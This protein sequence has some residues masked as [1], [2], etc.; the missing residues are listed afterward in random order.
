[1]TLNCSS[2]I[3]RERS[4][5]C[6]G[7]DLERDWIICMECISPVAPFESLDLCNSKVCLTSSCSRDY[8]K[9]MHLP[10]RCTLK[11]RK[12]YDR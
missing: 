7:R 6:C 5:G 1:M 9:E 11:F 3:R 8:L 2:E 12:C 10:Q 4:C